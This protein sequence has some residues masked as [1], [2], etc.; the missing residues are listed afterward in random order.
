MSD[1]FSMAKVP[2]EQ[3]LA[4]YGLLFAMADADYYMDAEEIKLIL[5]TLELDGMSE[6]SR[7]KLY[8]YLIEPPDPEECLNALAKADENLRYGAMMHILDIA[9]ADEILDL[10]EQD[11][12]ETAQ[13]VLEVNDDQKNAI[14]KFV[15]KARKIRDRGVDDAYAAKALSSAAGGLTAVGVPIAA[16]SF[17]GSVAGLSAAGISSGLA[18]LG[19]GFGMVG[20]IGIVILI[21][22]STY[23]GI[24]KVSHM[25]IDKERKKQKEEAEIKMRLVIDSMQRYVDH[26]M[27]QIESHKGLMQP[28]GTQQRAI[29]KLNERC[30]ALRILLAKHSEVTR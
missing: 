6:E 2:D 15:H 1:E 24:K 22:T 5:Q 28:I 20:G 8:N 19:L 3:R 30:M 10:A 26:L 21:G 4:F 11:I 12:I 9:W 25:H 23:M 13:I 7:R 29:E 14:E 17:S 18:A 16:V 27:E